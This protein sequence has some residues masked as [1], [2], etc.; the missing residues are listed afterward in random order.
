[1]KTQRSQKE[2]KKKRYIHNKKWTML[3]LHNTHHKVF[4]CVYVY[5]YNM[6]NVYL[7]VYVYI[8]KYK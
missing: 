2:L 6:R 3:S 4:M 7:Y 5:A 8:I 1:M